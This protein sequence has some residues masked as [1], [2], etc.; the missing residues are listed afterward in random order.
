[1]LNRETG[2]RLLKIISKGHGR[3]KIILESNKKKKI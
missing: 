2:S 3:S 1:M